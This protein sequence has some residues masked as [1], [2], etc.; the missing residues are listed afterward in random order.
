MGSACG[1]NPIPIIIPCHRVLAADR[2]LGG[3]SGGRGRE[4]KAQLLALEGA[5]PIQHS[6]AFG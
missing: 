4:T 1:A 2:E 5:W 3:F 6:F